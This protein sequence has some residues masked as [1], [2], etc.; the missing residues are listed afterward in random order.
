M[1]TIIAKHESTGM[2]EI[3]CPDD[4]SIAFGVNLKIND[5][6]ARDQWIQG[7]ECKSGEKACKYNLQD[8][9]GKDVLYQYLFC[10][11]NS[12]AGTKELEVKT[13]TNL[14]GKPASKECS[15]GKSTVGGFQLNFKHSKDNMHSTN[16]DVGFNYLQRG[17]K[18]YDPVGWWQKDR[19][20]VKN[21]FLM[22]CAPTT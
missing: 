10:L 13:S 2:K 8:V 18:G 6:K 22:V 3:S 16:G 7:D 20:R 21:S 9:N 15:E 11:H 14:D 5:Y 12:V 17:M 4:F 19:D 1:R